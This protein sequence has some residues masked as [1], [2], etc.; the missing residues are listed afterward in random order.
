MKVSWDDDILNTWK[1]ETCSKPPTRYV[2]TSAAQNSQ[3]SY[4]KKQSCERGPSITEH[5]CK[6]LYERPLPPASH[7]IWPRSWQLLLHMFVLHT[8]FSSSYSCYDCHFMCLKTCPKHNFYN[9]PTSVRGVCG[10]PAMFFQGSKQIQVFWFY[11][12]NRG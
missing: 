7:W 1:N 5:T 2:D 8:C 10:V 4:K 9:Y 11:R 12:P 6:L 3:K